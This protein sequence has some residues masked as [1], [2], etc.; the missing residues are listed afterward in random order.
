MK[1]LARMFVWW[2]KM[3]SDIEQLVK[4]CPQCQQVQPNPPTAPLHPW[5]WP[6]Q[7]WSR[8]HLDFAGLVQGKM[9]LVVVDAHS[10]AHPIATTTAKAT[11][12]QLRVMF[13]RWGIPETVVSDNGPQFIAH[14]YEYF[15]S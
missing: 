7:L 13:A 6:L 2:I 9:L 3:D 10:K 14:E 11:I 15:G 12:E 8:V 4:Q 5:C 1:A